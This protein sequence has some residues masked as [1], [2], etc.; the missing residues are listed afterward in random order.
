V[1]VSEHVQHHF[2]R[3]DG[4]AMIALQPTAV[5]VEARRHENHDIFLGF[6]KSASDALNDAYGDLAPTRLGLRYINVFN[7]AEIGKHLGRS[8]DWN[9][10][11]DGRF[12]KLPGDLADLTGTNFQSQT[13]SPIGDGR[14]TLR[15]GIEGAGDG[16]VFRLD[17]DRYQEG[18]FAAT[19]CLPLLRQFHEDIH[20]VFLAFAGDALTEWMEPKT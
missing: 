2:K 16:A 3:L 20:S 7:K 9:D 14:M 6:F 18:D 4:A 13:N 10:L 8:V 12:L 17:F 15:F 1:T 19:A 5:T 11:I